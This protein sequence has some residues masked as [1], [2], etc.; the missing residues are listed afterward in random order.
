MGCYRSHIVDYLSPVKRAICFIACNHTQNLDVNAILGSFLRQVILRLPNVSSSVMEWWKG[1]QI[2]LNT[3]KQMQLLVDQIGESRVD[4]AVDAFDEY[5][6]RDQLLPHLRQLMA[7]CRVYIIITTRPNLTPLIQDGDI[8]INIPRQDDDIRKFVHAQITSPTVPGNLLRNLPGLVAKSASIASKEDQSYKENF[9]SEVVAKSGGRLVVSRLKSITDIDHKFRML[10]ARL[11]L[12]RIARSRNPNQL[13]A[14]LRALSPDLD[15]AYD[16]SL[17]R[18]S[19]VDRDLALE[20]FS[21]I[22]LAQRPLEMIELLHA[23]VTRWDDEGQTDID[24]GDLDLPERVL[25]ICQGLVVIVDR[26]YK[27]T[28]TLVRKCASTALKLASD[29][30]G[31][32]RPLMIISGA[33]LWQILQNTNDTLTLPWC[34]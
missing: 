15:E 4:L 9:V 27:K 8:R 10:V 32:M 6:Y 12:L 11:H 14:T 2:P 1:S 13:Q 5:L 17:D 25:E 26:D 34:A 29:S 33:R 3:E 18:I 24:R 21:W 30:N 16:E 31:Q 7:T 20:T 28:L 23:V 22:T 19:S